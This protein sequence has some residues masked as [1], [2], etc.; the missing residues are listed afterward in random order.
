MVADIYGR[1]LAAR[2][3]D[4]VMVAQPLEVLPWYRLPWLRG[5]RAPTLSIVDGFERRVLDRH[6]RPGNRDLPDSDVLIAT[7]WETVEWAERIALRKGRRLH[8]V[9]GHEVFPWLPIARV[10][11]AYS[12]PIPKIVIS[13]WLENIMRAEYGA[14]HLVLIRNGL[15]HSQFRAGERGKQARPTVGLLFSEA[16]S[17]GFDTALK[18][19]KSVRRKLPSLR[20]RSFGFDCPSESL[21]DFVEFTRNPSRER[22]RDLYSQCDVWV[23]ASKSEG[24]NMTAVEAMACGTPVVT[25]ETG[26]P[27][28]GVRS[29]H[30]GYCVPIGDIQALQEG[31]ERVLLVSEVEWRRASSMARQSVGSLSWEESASVFERT[32]KNLV[33]NQLP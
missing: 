1:L 11:R 23:S 31:V 24:F 13:R 25:Y 15:D 6:R 19:L 33:E 26:W 14:E 17:K 21:P 20:V 29:G 32:L 22:L 3:H 10:R 5:K 16:P 4:V 9:Q 2:G 27:E 30:N 8:F 18:M 12:A 7:W 28:E